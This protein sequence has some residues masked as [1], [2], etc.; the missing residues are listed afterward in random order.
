[1]K[2]RT[3]AFN[4]GSASAMRRAC[5]S[6]PRHVGFTNTACRSSACCGSGDRN[7]LCNRMGERRGFAAPL[8]GAAWQVASLHSQPTMHSHSPRALVLLR[9]ADGFGELLRR[10]PRE[11]RIAQEFAG[12]L[13]HVG[14]AAPEDCFGLLRLRDQTDG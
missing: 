5:T 6:K 8:C 14:V 4:S 3:K 9:R 1:M 7:G 2:A 11:V 10:T 12:Q 13:D